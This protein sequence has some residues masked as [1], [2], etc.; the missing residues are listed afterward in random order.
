M[1]IYIDGESLRPDD[2]SE[3]EEYVKENNITF[4]LNTLSNI[5]EICD[6]HDLIFTGNEELIKL[7]IEKN[8]NIIIKTCYPVST[9]IIEIC[10]K[11]FKLFGEKGKVYP[12]IKISCKLEKL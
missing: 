9:D 2:F 4:Q 10:K 3:F 5:N 6:N 11:S 8:K 1:K 7:L 12:P